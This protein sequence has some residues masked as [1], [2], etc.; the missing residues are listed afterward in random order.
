MHINFDRERIGQ[1]L[2]GQNDMDDM[3]MDNGA[4][5]FEAQEGSNNMYQPH[6]SYDNQNLAQN[7][8]QQSIIYEEGVSNEEE[9]LTGNEKPQPLD[10]HP[11]LEGVT[12][13]QTPS[14]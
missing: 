2:D 3:N 12:F 8:F 9:D 10:E 7:Q 1:D 13:N 6:L 4:Q 5:D 14:K 11:Q